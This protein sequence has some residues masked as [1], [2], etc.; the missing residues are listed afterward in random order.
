[1]SNPGILKI[2]LYVETVRYYMGRD[3]TYAHFR[4]DLLGCPEM[5]HGQVDKDPVLI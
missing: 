2:I 3:A 4:Y 1:M 5:S